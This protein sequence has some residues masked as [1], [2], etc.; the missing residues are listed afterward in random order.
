MEYNH[1]A[2]GSIGMEF[3]RGM[4]NGTNLLGGHHSAPSLHVGEGLGRGEDGLAHVLFVD[5][6]VCLA[7]NSV[8]CTEHEPSYRNEATIHT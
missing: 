8:G 1:I 2:Q 7:T 5:L 4:G 6:T 3:Q